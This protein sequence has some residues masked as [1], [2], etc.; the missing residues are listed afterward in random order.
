MEFG[1]LMTAAFRQLN[2]D[3]L[4]SSLDHPIRELSVRNYCEEYEM[5]MNGKRRITHDLEEL[6]K[7]LSHLTSLRLSVVHEEKRGEQG[8]ILRMTDPHSF[9]L[10]FPDRFLKPTQHTLKHLTLYSSLPVGWFPKLD[11]REVH[12]A[13]LETLALGQFVFSHD[14]Q[15][16]WI[17]SHQASLRELYLDHCSILR[18]R[19]FAIHDWLDEDGFP[20]FN[21]PSLR[22]NDNY[23][24]WGDSLD[25]E[26]DDIQGVTR[27]MRIISYDSRWHQF[28]HRFAESLPHLRE[29]RFGTSTGW[30]FNTESPYPHDGGGLPLMPWEQETEITNQIFQER[31]LVYDDWETDYS[32]NWNLEDKQEE[33]WKQQGWLARLNPPPQCDEEDNVALQTLLSKLS[34][35]STA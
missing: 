7:S 29:F 32:V 6:S 3:N 13:T 35:S 14:S 17:L 34:M 10:G 27:C 2:L 25:P 22:Y 11:L 15:L 31:Y 20:R 5:D 16:E 19:A 18:Q 9:W 28:F 23:D 4:L 12:L 24:G 21:H 1:P 33:S 26:Y 30:D 8:P